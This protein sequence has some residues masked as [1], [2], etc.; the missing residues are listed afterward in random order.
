MKRYLA[1]L[2][3]ILVSV[4]TLAAI[5]DAATCHLETHTVIVNGHVVTQSVKVCDGEIT[6]DPTVDDSADGPR[7]SQSGRDLRC[8]GNQRGT[9]PV[10][11]L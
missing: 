6:I 3:A 7:D 1:S 9:G 4:P 10:L 8:D 11:L 2:L 5:A